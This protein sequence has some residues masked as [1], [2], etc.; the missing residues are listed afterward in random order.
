MLEVAIFLPLV[1]AWYLFCQEV[2][3]S[4]N[5]HRKIEIRIVINIEPF[6][7]AMRETELAMR[8]MNERLAASLPTLQQAVERMNKAL[9]Q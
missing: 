1:F 9:E 7:R 2:K 4:N 8:R 5:V 3:K 6:I